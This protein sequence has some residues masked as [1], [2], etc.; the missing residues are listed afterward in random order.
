MSTQ[1]QFWIWAHSCNSTLSTSKCQ[2][3]Q[4]SVMIFIVRWK[5]RSALTL[6]LTLLLTSLCQGECPMECYCESGT[7]AR[8][9]G[10]KLLTKF[11]TFQSSSPVTRLEL[12]DYRMVTFSRADF[13]RLPPNLTEL[14][15]CRNGLEV[16]EN[17][18][19]TSP[20]PLQ[21]RLL[22]LSGNGLR[23]FVGGAGLEN[24]RV[25]DLSSNHLQQVYGL[26]L[27]QSL[28][29]VNLRD[30]GISYLQPSTF[31]V[32]SPPHKPRTTQQN[33]KLIS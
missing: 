6:A 23:Y 5:M 32:L 4:I 8:C 20:T 1:A 3:D 2:H 21:L 17:A 13:L 19:F 16:L 28:E 15:M 30:N 18:T 22:D 12:H 27:L 29:S 26:T 7:I 10:D 9:A 31:Q 24:L 14:S 25:L 33:K 11:P